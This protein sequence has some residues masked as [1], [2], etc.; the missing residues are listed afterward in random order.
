MTSHPSQ[1]LIALALLLV[2]G[3]GGGGGDPYQEALTYSHENIACTSDA[4]CCVVFD[5]CNDTGMLVGKS[6]R[7]TVR[8]LLDS[9]H[10]TQC[11]ACINP[12]VQASCDQ[13]HC[14]AQRLDDSAG[15]AFLSDARTDHCGK[16]A[17]PAARTLEEPITVG[18]SAAALTVFSCGQ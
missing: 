1:V 7:Q 8:G 5:D 15:G 4:D 2:G 10:S 3:C 12:A 6:D 18:S 14:V 17:V 13:G 9:I 11:L 16:V